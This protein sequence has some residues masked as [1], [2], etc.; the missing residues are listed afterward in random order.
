MRRYWLL[1]A[2]STLSALI[3]QEA[4]ANDGSR[5]AAVPPQESG[6]EPSP[7]QASA[8]NI[9]LMLN[10]DISRLEQR[11]NGGGGIFGSW[12]FF[13]ILTRPREKTG[14]YLTI[15]GDTNLSASSYTTRRHE[16]MSTTHLDL[17]ADGIGVFGWKHRRPHALGLL[18]VGIP[19]N[20]NFAHEWNGVIARSAGGAGFGFAYVLASDASR[21]PTRQLFWQPTIASNRFF[22]F[23][24]AWIGAAL[25]A[26][27]LRQ[28]HLSDVTYAPGPLLIAQWVPPMDGVSARIAVRGTP[29]LEK[30]SPFELPYSEGEASL[31]YSGF[32]GQKTLAIL[33]F[34]EFRATVT[35]INIGW[36]PERTSVAG[37][38]FFGLTFSSNVLAPR[39]PLGTGVTNPGA[40]PMGTMGGSGGMP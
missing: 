21:E 36:V 12:E 4:V 29:G 24:G 5:V 28:L 6:P 17:R 35:T 16:R 10:G 40:M 9:G 31:R 33:P 37:L 2:A 22:A 27:E 19:I 39:M 11:S 8:W 30:G 23:A 34:L 7:P 26:P 32:S 25:I 3:A 18:G 38:V 20:A 14:V 15:D 13:P 1:I